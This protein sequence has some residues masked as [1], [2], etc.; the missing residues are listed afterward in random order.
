MHPDLLFQPF[1][2]EIQRNIRSI[3]LQFQVN[4]PTVESFLFQ[5]PNSRLNYFVSRF[6]DKF[7]VN[8]TTYRTL[9]KAYGLRFIIQVSGKAGKFNFIPFFTTVGSGIGLLSVATLVADCMLLNLTKKRK[10]YQQLKAPETSTVSYTPHANGSAD[11]A[12]A[13]GENENFVVCYRF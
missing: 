12:R 13:A 11:P 7:E 1:W 10:F 8:G 3:R 9:V 6:S 4:E 5:D 2:L